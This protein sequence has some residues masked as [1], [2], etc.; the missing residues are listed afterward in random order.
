MLKLNEFGLFLPSAL[1]TEQKNDLIQWRTEINALQVETDKEFSIIE[2]HIK[3]KNLPAIALT[4]HKEAVKQSQER[5]AT[6]NKNVDAVLNATDAEAEQAAL[7]TLTEFMQKQQFEK[8]MDKTNLEKLPFGIPDKAVRKP[9]E[10]GVAMMKYLGIKPTQIASLTTTGLL[11]NTKT[12]TPADLSENIEIQLTDAIKAK[13]VELH[14]N[15]VEIYTWV[16]N[17]VQFIPSYGSIQGA[18][19]TLQTLKGNSFDTAS[20]LIAL[21]RASNIPARYAYGTIEVPLDQLNN[22]VGG[23]ENFWAATNLLG[24]GGIP[25]TLIKWDGVFKYVHME[26][27]WVEAFVDF[28]PSRGVKNVA[29]DNWIPMD[30]SFKQY[31]FTQG[32]DIQNNV[33]F[34]A[35]ALVQSIQT[36]ATINESEGWVQNIPQAD[37]EQQLTA[38]QTQVQTYIETQNPDATLGEVLGLQQIKIKAAEPL[39][40]GLPYRVA[41]AKNTFT[42]IPDNLRHKFSYSLS[43][44]DYAGTTG[45]NYFTIT[46]TLPELAGK[47]LAL[48][49]KPATTEDETIILSYIPTV[50]TGGT[51]DPSKLPQ[52][53]PGN[54]IEMI[55]EFTIDGTVI[56]SANVG[57]LGSELK[58]GFAM[59]QPTG[60]QFPPT[61]NNVTVGQYHAIGLDLQG[62]SANQLQKLQVDLSNTKTKLEQAQTNA[63]ELDGVTKHEVVGDLLQATVQSYFAMNDIQ[64]ELLAQIAKGHIYRMPSYGKVSTHLETV[65]SWGIPRTVKVN[66]VIG[67]IDF[68][69]SIVGANN[70]DAK[71]QKALIEQVGIVNSMM[72]HLVPENIFSTPET[73]SYGISAVKAIQL[74]QSEGQKI[75]HITKANLVTTLDIINLNS[76]TEQEISDAVNSG[77]EVTTHSH[78]LNFHGMIVAG[79]IILDPI[80]GTGAYKIA[81]G[82]DGFWELVAL[83]LDIILLIIGIGEITLAPVTLGILVGLSV[84]FN[85]SAFFNGLKCDVGEFTVNLFFA[86]LFVFTFLPVA[87]VTSVIAYLFSLMLLG[88]IGME[89]REYC[90]KM[91]P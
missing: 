56:A 10:D 16:H 71:Q 6:F 69:L 7:K 35:D 52:S 78:K 66:G 34:N 67:D 68:M 8:S 87:G 46:K 12:P 25:H 18:D 88:G 3:E 38:F 91:M 27:I 77:Y 21:L 83:G 79:Y 84:Y 51:L 14:K 31:D 43:Q 28:E 40:A 80:K 41:S 44:S 30:A 70:N 55:A 1:T 5:V 53:L 48:S 64:D 11:E 82:Q 63:S 32:M 17:N 22:W 24:Q 76:S 75:Y 49:Y 45:A 57:K 29:G 26:H 2:A 4:R 90:R 62:I 54:L 89:A 86:T 65:Y 60:S 74:A 15:P 73:P 23:V 85:I 72:E 61:S 39:A 81:S 20:L 33:P 59:V 37:I 19:Y 13:A 58:D 50:P 47:K 42:E 9:I 36:K